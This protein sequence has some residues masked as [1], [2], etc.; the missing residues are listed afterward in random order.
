MLPSRFNGRSRL[1]RGRTRGR[2][3]GMNRTEAAYSLEVLGP[4]LNSGEILWWAYQPMKFR[5]ADGA[6]YEP[7]FVVQLADGTLEVHE[8]KGWRFEDDALVKIKVAA[9]LY[10]MFIWRAFTSRAKRDGGGWTERVFGASDQ[11]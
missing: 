3:E 2:T 10:P 11:P 1:A 5:L 8:V 9:S 7:D 4:R 6:T